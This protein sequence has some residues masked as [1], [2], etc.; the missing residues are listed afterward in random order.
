MGINKDLG[1]PFGDGMEKIAIA[2]DVDGTLID[3]SAET[4]ENHSTITLFGILRMQKWKNVSILVWSGG[5]KQYAEQM[6]RDYVSNDTDGITFHS[7]LEHTELRKKYSKIIAIDDVQDT[8]LGD[9]NLIVRN[10]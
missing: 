1:L 6:F 5:G 10:K 9:V 2:F 3:S 7:K 8:R 4:L